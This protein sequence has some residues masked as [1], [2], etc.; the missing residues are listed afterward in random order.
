M[1]YSTSAIFAQDK[2]D[3][4]YYYLKRQ[5]LWI[6]FGL[7]GFSVALNID[8]R[9]FR[10][11]S[12]PILLISMFLLALVFVPGIGRAAGG[13]RRWIKVGAFSFQP[14]ELA[15]LAV[16]LF[17][18][19]R[20]T[21]RRRHIGRFWRALLFPLLL[22]C[23]VMGL[24]I[25]QPD[26]GT[27]ILIALIS[28]IL[29]FSTGVPLKL[30]FPAVLAAV[31]AVYLLVFSSS[32][33][34]RRIT[35]FLNPWADPEGAGFQIIQSFIALGSGGIGGMGLAQSRQKFYYLPAAHTDFIFSI[36]GEE[37]GFAGAIIILGLFLVIFI[38]GMR[39]ARGAPDFFGFLLGIGIVSI[40][41]LQ[42][43]INIAVVTGSLPT[44]GLP[45]PFISFG[46]SSMLFNLVAIGVLMNIGRQAEAPQTRHYLTRRA[47]RGIKI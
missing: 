43:L 20:L 18:A 15:K 30:L 26:L 8:Y 23:L 31:P 25:L 27:T 40:I 45:L 7:I 21:V 33:R 44:K 47:R 46:G 6:I 5:A 29:L 16:I 10:K 14:S 42:A 11:Y 22:T 19:D 4:S 37:L 34:A 39:L 35:A 41:S 36:I 12:M 1:I 32:Y 24:V 9:D 28:A 2:Y 38:V 17:L 13:A 3:D